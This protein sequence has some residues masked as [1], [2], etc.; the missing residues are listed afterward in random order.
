MFALVKWRGLAL[1]VALLFVVEGVQ[2]APPA[3]GP[4]VGLV[5]HAYG[6]GGA[7][8]SARAVLRGLNTAVGKDARLAP[9]SLEAHFNDP[10][11]DDK[12]L[13]E[14]D[15]KVREARQKLD[16][17]DLAEATKLLKV[18]L[19]LYEK[20]MHRL[21]GRPKPMEPV[22][23]ALKLLAAARFI[24]GDAEGARE[25]LRRARSLDPE[26]AYDAKLYPPK[27][28]RIFTEV[29][30]LLDELGK[31]SLSVQS[32][33]PGAEVFLNGVPSGVAPVRIQ[34]CG[35]GANFLTFVATGFVPTTVTVEVTGGEEKKVEQ[36][37]GRYDDDPVPLLERTRASM[38]ELTAATAARELGRR[39]HADLLLLAFVAEQGDS[40]HF[41]VYLY[42]LR[43]GKLAKQVKRAAPIGELESAAA[44]AV[45]EI[46]PGKVAVAPDAD[47]AARAGQ[48][49]VIVRT[50][51]K[52][53]SWKY[54]WHSVA[55]IGGV[56]LISTIAGVAA[57][58]SNNGI[59]PRYGVILTH[60]G[61]GFSF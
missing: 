11:A 53:R 4:R 18:A 30:L 48:P 44:A 40:A 24:D 45:A 22:I 5:A 60:R 34:S 12:T 16:E 56:V 8:A 47:D 7:A 36:T 59:D 26:L 39:V 15:G 9:S 57:A 46:D 61:L 51:K 23:G 58:Q 29:K 17:L 37:L 19:G 2:A 13:G 3:A 38:G 6:D 35:A 55:V 14:A 31:G 41:S 20:V 43:S 33:P 21:A 42:D 52:W 50:A 49:N 54:F 28:R 1:A 32:D 25:A 10:A 27:M